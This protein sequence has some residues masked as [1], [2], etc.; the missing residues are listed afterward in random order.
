VYV[1]LPYDDEKNDTYGFPSLDSTKSHLKEKIALEHT[2]AMDIDM[3]K[4]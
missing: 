2:D 4:R 3:G 1:N